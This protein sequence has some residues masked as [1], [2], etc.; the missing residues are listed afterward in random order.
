LTMTENQVGGQ[1]GRYKIL[2]QIGEG[3]CGTV[4]M[5]EQEEPVR[6]RVALKVIKPGM[7]TREVVARFE[8]ERQALALMDHANIARVLDAGATPNGRPYFVME[9][10]R[11]IKITDY[12]NQN[13]LTTRERL[14]LF[15][16]VCRAIQH[17][18]QK[19]VIHRDI[20]PSNILVTLDEKVALPKVI[21]FGIAKAIQGRLTNQT[22]FTAFQQFLG[23]PTYMSPEQ[24]EMT[25]LDIDTRSDIY[26]LGVLLYEL[27]TDTT[28][29]DAKELV[30]SG[31]DGM[32]RT[33]REREPVRPST[34]L[35]TMSELEL[36]ATAGHRKADSS[37]LIHTLKG[38]LDWI[39][40]KCLEKDRTRRYETANGLAMDVQRYLATMPVVARPPSKL[41]RFQKLVQRN[42]LAF[43]ATNAVALSLLIGFAVSTRLFIQERRARQRA[44]TAERTQERLRQEAENARASEAALRWQAVEARKNEARLRLQAEAA[45]RTAQSEASQLGEA[46]MAL[47]NLTAAEEFIRNALQMQR[48]LLG[49][50]NAEVAVSLNNLAKVLAMQGKLPEAETRYRDALTLEKRLLGDRNPTVGST[51]GNLALV[52]Q[53]QGEFEEAAKHFGDTLSH[54][55][56]EPGEESPTPAPFLG[57]ILHHLAEVLHRLGRL[58]EAR[59][60][61]EEAI[62]N[63]RKHLDWPVNERHHALD[64]LRAVLTDQ[65]D[66]AGIAA[67]EVESQALEAEAQRREAQLPI[68]PPQNASSRSRADFFAQ[69]GR[70]KD[71]AVDAARALQAAPQDHM[72]YHSLAP[73]LVATGD[74]SGYQQLCR[75]ILAQFG[76]T[77]NPSSPDRFARDA[78]ASGSW[79][80][81]L[82]GDPAIAD[83]MAKD[84]L[85][86]PNSGADLELVG[87]LSDVAVK[88]GEKNRFL[89]YFHCTRGLA[90]YRQGRFPAAIAWMQM[91]LANDRNK[92]GHQWDDYLYV[93]AYAVIG[94]AHHRM[95][96]M[97][98]ARTALAKAAEFAR[99]CLPPL[100][101][102]QIGSIWRDWIVANALLDEARQL[103]AGGPET[104][105]GPA[106]PESPP[107]PAHS[108]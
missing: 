19:G 56:P 36:T 50:N 46:M 26:S 101:S 24:A 70:W 86:L 79:R 5:A 61:A 9:L 25:S 72:L 62:S 13:R 100:E 1:I 92:A 4:Y 39:V 76:G 33:I 85:I 31:L 90:D 35:S 43:L 58:Q 52:L 66:L 77:N 15:I 3:G 68:E 20:K 41:Y 22:L 29:F 96:A 105:G 69:R 74:I 106:T 38:D 49:D 53:R 95:G 94:M 88:E 63:Y 104:S 47:G 27:L 93:E 99:K 67:L 18:H 6:R 84:C 42:R 21:D 73:L 14:E 91:T 57:L 107:N 51:L 2:Q 54:Y 48:K 89:P 82:K 12:C 11:G 44:V 32:R 97:L 103:T 45:E 108:Q 7:D 16:K 37:R 10:V 8:A 81:P 17:A 83:R 65:G 23:T 98:E 28:P 78:I 80:V 60:F 75:R 71:A 55:R 40:I 102:G 59:S 64:V 30:A 87:E 34:R